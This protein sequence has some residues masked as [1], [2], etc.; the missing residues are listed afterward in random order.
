MMRSA[1][2]F[3]LAF[4]ASAVAGMLACAAVSLWPDWNAGGGRGLDEAARG[5]L[6]AAYVALCILLYGFAA[7]RRD[8]A[9]HLKRALHILLLAPL[10][11]AVLGV[12]DHGIHGIDWLHEAVGM[13]QMVAPP[14]SVALLQWLILQIYLSRQTP[15]AEPASMSAPGWH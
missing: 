10:L 8:R 14:W 7:W 9:R 15:P 5:L 4:V 1:G 11:V 2:V 12:A 13:L 3:V 6:T